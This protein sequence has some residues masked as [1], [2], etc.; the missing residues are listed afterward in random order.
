VP[1]TSPLPPTLSGRPTATAQVPLIKLDQWSDVV[2]RMQPP[3]DAATAQPVRRSKI[4]ELSDTLHCSI[5]GT[6]L[7]NA[8]LRH[9]LVRLDAKG[10]ESADEHELHVLGVMLAGRRESGA[11]LLQRALDRRHGLS[12]KQYGR[13]KDEAELRRMWDESVRSGDIPGA[14]WA[15]LSHPLA[16]EAIIKKAFRDVHMLS[17]LVG[18]A[19]RADIRRLRQLEDELGVLTGKLERQQKQLRDGFTSRDETIRQLKEML[20]RR[21]EHPADDAARDSDAGGEIETLRSVIAELNR[22][23]GQETARR[24]RLEQRL[25]AASSNMQRTEAALRTMADER[26][27]FVRDLELVE[28]QLAG[29]IKEPTD[30]AEGPLELAGR[31]ILYVGGRANQIPQMKAMVER[32]GA[33]FL[34]HDGGIEHSAALLPG[35]VGRADHLFFPVD[36]ISHD[37]VA[38]IKK[39]CRQ[40]ERPYHPLRTASLAALVASLAVASRHQGAAIAAEQP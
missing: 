24:E 38:T 17:H 10:V 39:L 37:A 30:S 4:W 14:Y 25:H 18:A 16:S 36:C 34:H 7:S 9:V 19:N 29:L 35:L 13:A 2:L 33:R 12:I 5:I 26:D 15:L 22:K 40:L 32:M 6:C 11:K 27:A 8:E 3:A 23:L 21:A 28:D 20:I 1:V 31:T